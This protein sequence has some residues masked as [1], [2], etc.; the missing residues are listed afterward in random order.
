[1]FLKHLE[2][3][4]K[5]LKN[6]F[7]S[8]LSRSVVFALAERRLQ[9]EEKIFFGEERRGACSCQLLTFI[10]LCSPKFS[11]EKNIHLLLGS[12]QVKEYSIGIADI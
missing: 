1:M 7:V 12:S 11:K 6:Q 5:F 10:T 3:L 9:K 8:E 2:T 4:T